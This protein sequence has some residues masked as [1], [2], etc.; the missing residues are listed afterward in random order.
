MFCQR[1]LFL[2]RPG[3]IVNFVRRDPI[4][5]GDD[6]EDV[7]RS[8]IRSSSGPSNTPS[9]SPVRI[10]RIYDENGYKVTCLKSVYENG[11]TFSL[12]LYFR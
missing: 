12:T 4:V 10:F 6:L 11:L 5:L 7:D 2:R 8:S 9:K 3:V 1:V